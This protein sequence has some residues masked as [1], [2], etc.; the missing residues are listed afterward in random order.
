MNNENQND[1]LNALPKTAD[2]FNKII[3]PKK[4]EKKINT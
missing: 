2:V 1:N 4:K 3:K